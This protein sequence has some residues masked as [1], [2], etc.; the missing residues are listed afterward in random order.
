MN[1][2]YVTAVLL[3][4]AEVTALSSPIVK[5]AS[6]FP[7]FKWASTDKVVFKPWLTV[8]GSQLKNIYFHHWSPGSN[9]DPL[10]WP[11]LTSS[12]GPPV[13]YTTELFTFIG[14]TMDNIQCYYC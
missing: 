6:M 4:G 7:L 13:L 11:A 2:P 3:A 8:P 12:A 9:V 5:K 1:N 14:V 10:F